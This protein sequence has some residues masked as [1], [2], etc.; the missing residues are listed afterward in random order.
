MKSIY[1]TL[2]DA[3]ELPP[4]EPKEKTEA[5]DL[6]GKEFALAIV[7]SREFRSFIVDGILDGKINAA[8]VTRLMDY[9]W[10]KP[11]ERLEISEPPS[12]S[13][14]SADELRHRALAVAR[15]IV[16][17]SQKRDDDGSIH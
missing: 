9:A 16:K 3:F 7:N 15:T 17:A 4:G 12:L 6:S 13:E 5:M 14:L 1:D 10:G 8:I 2:P 11:T